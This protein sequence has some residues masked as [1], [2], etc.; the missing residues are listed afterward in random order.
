MNTIRSASIFQVAG[1]DHVT[2]VDA[3]SKETDLCQWLV[4]EGVVV[5][6]KRREK[7]LKELV[8]K[9]SKAE[10]KAKKDRVSWNYAEWHLTWVSVGIGW[11]SHTRK[12]LQIG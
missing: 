10:E 4:A 1:L 11:H 2:L 3:E 12:T 6:E 5:A 9:Y 8:E 7:H